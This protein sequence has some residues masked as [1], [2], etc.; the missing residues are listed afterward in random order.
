[1]K[2]IRKRFCAI[3]LGCVLMCAAG[4]MVQAQVESGVPPQ[5]QIESGA[6]QQN[7]ISSAVDIETQDSYA[8]LSEMIVMV[9]EE[10]IHQF[11][12]FFGR[13]VVLVEPFYAV[14]EFG[15]RNDTI[16]GVTVRDQIVAAINNTTT[17]MI[18]YG[19]PVFHQYVQGVI[20]EI[21]GL[22]RLHVSGMNE[23]GDKRSFV[24]NI[25][26]SEPIYRSLHSFR[27]AHANK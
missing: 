5:I 13:S 16:L 25:E 18:S 23:R 7:N 20:Q 9:S 2:N 21:D 3:S 10:A 11:D 26:M 15:A 19:T 1:M 6:A 14:D 24:V 22:L 27:N 17:G 4:G 12:G 8:T